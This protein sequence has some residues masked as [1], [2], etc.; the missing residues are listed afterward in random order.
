MPNEPDPE[1][2]M[3][4]FLSTV[5]GINELITALERDAALIEGF[6]RGKSSVSARRVRENYG[7]AERGEHVLDKIG[8]DLVVQASG[9]GDGLRPRLV[10]AKQR[11]F[12]MF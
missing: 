7:A 11:F 6:D 1:T 12:V 3:Q 9:D 4:A 5:D 2:I 10:A 8:W